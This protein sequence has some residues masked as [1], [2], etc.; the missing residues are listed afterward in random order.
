MPKK[1]TPGYTK[2]GQYRFG[3]E[4]AWLCAPDRHGA[5]NWDTATG[6]QTALAAAEALSTL[7]RHHRS[8][9]SAADGPALL[10]AADAG[11]VVYAGHSMGG[12]GAWVLATSYPDRALGVVV[13]AGWTSKQ[14]YGTS[15]DL[16]HESSAHDISSTYLGAA[17]VASFLAAVLTR[18]YL[19]SVCSCQEILRRNGRG[20][21]P[22]WPICWSRPCWSP[23]WTSSRATSPVCRCSC[24]WARRMVRAP[25]ASHAARRARGCCPKPT[26][27]GA[28]AR[29]ARTVHAHRPLARRV[30]ADLPG[31]LAA[32]R[33]VHR[34]CGGGCC[35]CP[36]VPCCALVRGVWGDRL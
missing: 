6:Q 28:P 32:W 11:S 18:I 3:V 5:H 27:T 8:P 16:P 19:C 1:G 20:Q 2:K 26:A 29:T 23:T 12:H 33:H 21:S 36:C 22:R 25:T 17:A 34:V 4:H 14:T 31:C 9:A 7:S 24:V 30:S 10:P 15:N 13:G 35:A